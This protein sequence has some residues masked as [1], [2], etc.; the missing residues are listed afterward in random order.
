M[1]Q[2]TEVEVEL[3]PPLHQVNPRARWWWT[4]QALLT[5]LLLL[6]VEYLVFSWFSDWGPTPTAITTCSAVL[7]LLYLLVMPHWRFRVHRWETS[8]DAVYTSSGWLWQ[9][10][11]VA[12]L[13]RIQTVDMQ[14]GPLQLL[15]GL[16]S[17]RVTTAS[18]AGPVRIEGLT[19]DAAQG[20]VR[21]LTRRTQDT[22]GDAT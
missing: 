15:F 1:S 20:I 18:A 5:S 22:P 7:G 12:P 13:S 14:R 17:V 21:H 19:P 11:R 4:A 6:G 3:R 8:R 2:S 16:S 10:W 9:E